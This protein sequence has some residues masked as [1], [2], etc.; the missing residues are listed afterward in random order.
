[1]RSLNIE[2][3]N[4]LVRVLQ[5]NKSKEIILNEEIELGFNID[6]VNYIKKN[7]KEAVSIFSEKFSELNLNETNTEENACVLLNTSQSFLNVIP[8]DFNEEKNNIDSH[9]LWDLSNYFPDTYKDYIIK[10]YRLN[11]NYLNEKIDEVLLIAVDKNR[12]DVIKNLCNGI[13]F[14]IVNIDIDQFAVEKCLKENYSGEFTEQN[15]LLIGFKDSRI[16]FSLISKGKIRYY[17]FQNPGKANFKILIEKQIEFL[18]SVFS[19]IK[20]EQAFI[21]GT[22]KSINVQNFINEELKIFPATIINPSKINSSE[23][24]QSRYAPLYGLALKNFS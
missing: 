24:S 10:Y 14:K 15:I 19:E 5:L 18:T 11:N 8:V 21:Y 16:D 2:F 12:V 13:G 20:I 17:D 23:V 9:I 4:N 7:K 22:E 1:M 6:D 3:S